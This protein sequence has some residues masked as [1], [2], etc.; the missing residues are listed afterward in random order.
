MGW[1]LDAHWGALARDR[2]WRAGVVDATPVA[3]TASPAGAAYSQAAAR[4]EAA[5]F[6][7]GRPFVTRDEADRTLATHRRLR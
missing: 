6:L 3:H 1:G 2:G 4:E 7:A 5:A